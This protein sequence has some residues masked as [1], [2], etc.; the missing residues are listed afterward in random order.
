MANGSSKFSLLTLPVPPI[1]NLLK[2]YNM[3]ADITSCICDVV[4]AHDIL[5]TLLNQSCIDLSSVINAS[6]NLRILQH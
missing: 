2:F 4:Q 1:T 5:T 3:V 6:Q